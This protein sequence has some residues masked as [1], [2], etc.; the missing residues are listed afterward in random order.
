MIESRRYV[1][2]AGYRRRSLLPAP[3]DAYL[4][5]FFAGNTRCKSKSR[6]NRNSPS[7]YSSKSTCSR[8]VSLA[9]FSRWLLLLCLSLRAAP[10]AAMTTR[11]P[12][13]TPTPNEVDD[14]LLVSEGSESEYDKSGIQY[15]YVLYFHHFIPRSSSE[16]YLGPVAQVWQVS[17]CL[18]QSSY[19]MQ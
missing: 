9:E 7:V 17:S 14:V 1:V 3:C 18:S 15:G 19:R 2:L 6:Q 8:S 16:Q 13:K 12:R 11:T 4:I 10:I 5:V